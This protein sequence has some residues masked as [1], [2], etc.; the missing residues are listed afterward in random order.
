MENFTFEQCL[1]RASKGHVMPN[2]LHRIHTAAG[3]ENPPCTPK[4]D[5]TWFFEKPLILKIEYLQ[6]CNLLHQ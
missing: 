6:V 4:A 3:W 2:L 1:V 5:H